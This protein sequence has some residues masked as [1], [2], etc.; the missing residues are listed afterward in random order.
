MSRQ[1][2][3]SQVS[4]SVPEQ[5]NRTSFTSVLIPG[6]CP[7]ALLT[8]D[9]TRF[10]LVFNSSKI[11]AGSHRNLPFATIVAVF[12]PRPLSEEV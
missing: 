7:F 6:V 5:F 9:C 2:R 3:Y 10:Y 1:Y 4:T 8:C 11:Q 12:G